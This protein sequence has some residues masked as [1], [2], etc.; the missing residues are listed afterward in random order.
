MMLVNLL[1]PNTKH[2]TGL[3]PK[4]RA[5]VLGNLETKDG[6]ENVSTQA[7]QYMR[8][9]AALNVAPHFEWHLGQQD[10]ATAFLNTSLQKNVLVKPPPFF[11]KMG[12]TKEDEV[13]RLKKAVYGLRSSLLAW[14]TQRDQELENKTFVS[15]GR[16]MT[17]HRCIE[18][19]GMYEVIETDTGKLQG[20]ITVYV[21]D[22]LSMGAKETV[23]DVKLMI[24]KLW[25]VKDQG[26]L[27]PGDT[28]KELNFLGIRI[29]RGEQGELRVDQTKWLNETLLDLGWSGLS[30][31][32]RLP[33]IPHGKWIYQ[34]KTSPGNFTWLKQTQ[35]FIGNL[36]WISLRTRP[37]ITAITNMLASSTTLAPKQV[38]TIAKGVFRYLVGRQVTNHPVLCLRQL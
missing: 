20:L 26:T 15:N 25:K 8:I 35:T 29:T 1:K 31:R 10:I 17:L 28:K 9:R 7:P 18:E 5:V 12:W 19:P 2:R 27:A 24:S 38:C 3:Q 30:G 22:I 23:E 16:S 21:D 32:R 33:P 34:A 37:D 4:V 36:Q 6:E 11:T 14:C 13:W